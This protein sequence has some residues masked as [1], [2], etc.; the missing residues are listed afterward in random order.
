MVLTPDIQTSL[1]NAQRFFH[2]RP[3]KGRDHFAGQVGRSDIHP[4]IFV[5]LAAKELAA[6]VPFSRM[7]SARSQA[8]IIDQ[9]ST[10]FPGNDVFGFMEGIGTEVA[11]SY[12]AVCLC[13][14]HDSLCGILMTTAYAPARCS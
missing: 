9:Q 11:R 5:D 2:L 8:V 7:I 12:P 6:V 1:R 4:G 3:Q 13:S 14:G 10:A